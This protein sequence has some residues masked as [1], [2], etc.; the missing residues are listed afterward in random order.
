VCDDEKDAWE[1]LL[2]RLLDLETD[3]Q[4]D[5][6]VWEELISRRPIIGELECMFCDCAPAPDFPALLKHMESQHG[7]FI[8]REQYCTDRRGLIT[9]MQKQLCLGRGCFTCERG[10]RSLNA[11]RRH[12]RDTGHSVFDIDG[13]EG[14]YIDYYDYTPQYPEGFLDEVREIAESPEELEQLL[15]EVRA[16][17]WGRDRPSWI[18]Q[19]LP[20]GRVIGVREYRRQYAPKVPEWIKQKQEQAAMAKA[21]EKA[22]GFR[23]GEIEAA[24]PGEAIEE[25]VERHIDDPE[26]RQLVLQGLRARLE[27][28]RSRPQ[29]PDYKRDGKYT[30]QAALSR[31]MNRD[32]PHFRRSTLHIYN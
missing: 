8:P 7:F 23:P 12:M 27:S 3:E 4:R 30:A 22:L 32:K 1:Q 5:T 28:Y 19:I 16:T 13:R 24:G 25:K 26:L 10:F 6:L 15:E 17:P 21:M 2:P 20:S 14:E 11:C 31:D 18:G 29:A 9:Y